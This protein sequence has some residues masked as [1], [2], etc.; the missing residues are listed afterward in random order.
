[1]T[2][3]T[4]TRRSLVAAG[5]FGFGF[6]AVIDVLVLHHVLQLHHLLSGIYS[7]NTLEGLRVNVFAD[8]VFTT[9]M[10]VVMLVGAGLLWQSERRT[11][12]PLAVRPIAGA[13]VIGL[14]LFDLFDVTV[15]HVLLGLHQ[16]VQSLG[17][18]Y[19]PYWAAIS[20]LVIGAG[21]YVYRT[22]TDESIRPPSAET[23]PGG[24]D[25][26]R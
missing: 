7:M 8:G 1:M 15:D 22:G 18:V 19:N 12:V 21:I 4:L 13:A 14:G 25:E 23:T 6:S 24:S 2:E 26:P 20:L 11:D 17:G 5:I 9:V 16:P 10:L 3:R